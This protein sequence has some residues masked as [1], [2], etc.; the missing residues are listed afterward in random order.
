MM[1]DNWYLS[2]IEALAVRYLALVDHELR[3]W[4]AYMAMRSRELRR[5]VRPALIKHCPSNSTMVCGYRS[6]MVKAPQMVSTWFP[7]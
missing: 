5:G 2:L 4:G 6:K 3:C 1:T 7:M